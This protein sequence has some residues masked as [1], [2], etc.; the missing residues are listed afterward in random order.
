MRME[1]DKLEE[2]DA[3]KCPEDRSQAEK[4]S[5][6]DEKTMVKQAGEPKE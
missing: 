1:V 3:F 6:Q 5:K 4:V 2:E